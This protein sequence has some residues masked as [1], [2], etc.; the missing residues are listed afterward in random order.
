VANFVSLC[1]GDQGVSKDG[2]ALTYAGVP[3]HRVV[4]GFVVQGG[5]VAHGRDPRLAGSGTASTYGGKFKDEAGGLKLKHSIGTVG[6]ANSG[7]HGNASQFYIALG[8]AAAACD[9][10]HVV[11]GQVVGDPGGVLARV[12]AEAGSPSGAPRVR[13]AV[14]D[15][16]V[17]VE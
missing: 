6:M 16:G 4:S 17:C 13:V 14:G 8:P 7:K 15:C 3:F 5:D 9:G 2:V 10:K 12:D 11:V 1:A